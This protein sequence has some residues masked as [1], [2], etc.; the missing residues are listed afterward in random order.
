MEGG[1]EGREGGGEVGGEARTVGAF[2]FV[3]PEKRFLGALC[4]WKYLGFRV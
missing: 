1:V 2:L 3:P 4:C